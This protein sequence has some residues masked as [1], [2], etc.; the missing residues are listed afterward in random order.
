MATKLT[1][2]QEVVLTYLRDHGAKSSSDLRIVASLRGWTFQPRAVAVALE[3]KGL[4][5]QHFSALLNNSY[6][7]AITDQHG[8]VFRREGADF[9]YCGCKYWEKDRCIDCGGTEPKPEEKL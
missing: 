4:V 6:W 7:E 8:N 1:A 5:K 2:K 9:C 3:R